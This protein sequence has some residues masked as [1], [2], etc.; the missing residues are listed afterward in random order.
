MISIIQVRKLS[1]E[2]LSSLPEVTLLINNKARIQINLATEPN[3]SQCHL[4]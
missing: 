3:S 4:S 2:R 1:S